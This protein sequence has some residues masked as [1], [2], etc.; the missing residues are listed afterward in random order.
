MKWRSLRWWLFGS[1]AYLLFLL[2][3]F[4]AQY[5]TGWLSK[6]LPGVR[7]DGV[8]G[9][10]FSGHADGLQV[11]GTAL[12]TLQW[13]FDWR[14]PFS[15]SYGYR[16][17]LQS[18]SGSL[19]GRVDLRGS[20][21]Y[22]RDLDGRVPVSALERWLP[23]PNHSVDGSLALHLKE[24]D[25][26]SGRLDSAEGEVELD[27]GVLS[28]PRAFTLGSYRMTLAPAAEGGI[29]AELADVV[30]PL[31]LRA[32]LSLSPEG[33]YHLSGVLAPRDPSDPATKS[34]LAGLG[35]PDS[36]GQYPFDFKGQW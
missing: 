33:A 12:G 32:A 14:A 9:T 4:P 10:V 22:L 21:L 28:W 16:F 3:M 31:K 18:D 1:L 35:T 20:S 23:L 17:Q 27:D 24:L 2:T 5:I 11:Q 13:Q 15:L 36:T 26:K 7:L 19:S 25:V 34:F 6:H 30:S 8:S 29:S